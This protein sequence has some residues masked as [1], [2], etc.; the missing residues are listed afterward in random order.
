MQ[1]SNVNKTC[2]RFSSNL[3][4]KSKLIRMQHVARFND[5]TINLPPLKIL[6]KS[7]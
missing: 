5:V 6:I 2:K 4:F 1:K 7:L 3:E